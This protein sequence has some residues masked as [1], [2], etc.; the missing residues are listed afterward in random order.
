MLTVSLEVGQ[1]LGSRYRVER[2]VG[3]GAAGAVYEASD[4]GANRRVAIMV[5]SPGS[6]KGQAGAYREHEAR[7]ASRL[8]NQHVLEV[9]DILGLLGGERCI[10]ME[11]VE[12]E[13]LAARM[14]RAGQISQTDLA[15]LLVQA[16]DGLAA[17]HRAG[18]LHRCLTPTSLVVLEAAPGRPETV[19]IADFGL[20]KRSRE[21]ESEEEVPNYLAPEQVL[22]SRE[23]DVKS[24]VFSFGVIIYR[25]L[26]GC[27]PWSAKTAADFALQVSLHEPTPVED[28]APGLSPELARIVLKAMARA[29]EA[30]F[31]DAGEMLEAMLQWARG[32]FLT[33][34]LSALE[35][36]ETSSAPSG[37]QA[38]DSTSDRLATP[39]ESAMAVTRPWPQA[40]ISPSD[41]AAA[42]EDPA[43]AVT[44]PL[45][46][47]VDSTAEPKAASEPSA[48]ALTRPSHRAVS[49][50]VKP[51]AIAG[52]SASAPTRPLPRAT[53]SPSS[54]QATLN[55]SV[56]ADTKPLP[57]AATSASDAPPAPPPMPPPSRPRAAPRPPSER[58]PVIV[59]THQPQKPR[60]EE[61]P[62]ESVVISEPPRA[63]AI[64]TAAMPAIDTIESHAVAS[65][66]RRGKK[67]IFLGAA[68]LALVGA[69]TVLTELG[70][71]P[72]ARG[73]A[74]TEGRQAPLSGVTPAASGRAETASARV[75]APSPSEAP[76]AG[77]AAVA[78]ASAAPMPRASVEELAALPEPPSLRARATGSDAARA[79]ARTAAGHKPIQTSRSTSRPSQETKREESPA[80]APAPAR[81]DLPKSSPNPYAYR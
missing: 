31:Q 62:V 51:L 81:A 14:G 65:R 78:E 21:T 50:A 67:S 24:N 69:G 20:V 15:P 25:A 8:G 2:L 33:D 41:P 58:T 56:S 10:V 71:G 35:L 16:L 7:A 49:R 27:L 55:A 17:A 43:A 63:G 4:I 9:L 40:A 76:D 18:I 70:M 48:L 47:T 37:P 29:P 34:A 42:L 75:A 60:S 5:L 12:G 3:P 61:A 32:N 38:A 68:L 22:S 11:H 39:D 53:N 77:P 13:T 30:R 79:P 23:I 66:S 28:L 6:D 57:R 80:P 74:R 52:A 36:L 19:K 54:P 64:S 73:S 72:F 26:T 59:A 44:Q 46:R 1:V 45:P